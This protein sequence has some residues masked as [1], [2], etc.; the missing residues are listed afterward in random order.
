M[1][2]KLK[3]AP[4]YSVNPFD[5]Q[6]GFDEP[7]MSDIDFLVAVLGTP[8][9]RFGM[10]LSREMPPRSDLIVAARRVLD[11][12]GYNLRRIGR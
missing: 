10:V 8:S 2:F 12:N 9:G 11:F 5:T 6:H 1:H 4:E 3:M 7:L